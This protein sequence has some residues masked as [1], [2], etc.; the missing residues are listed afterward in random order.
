M[1]AK[2]SRHIATALALI[3]G[4][5]GV[6]GVLYAWG[7][8]PFRASTQ[9]TDDAYVRGQVTTLA[10]QV[11]GN[12]KLVAV[13]DYQRVAAGDLLIQL[14]DSSYVQQLASARAQLASAEASL[15][16]TAQDRSIAKSSVESADAA[17]DSAEAALAGAKAD[18]DRSSQLRERGVVTRSDDEDLQLSYRQATASLRQAKAQAETAR[19]KLAAI[20]IEER[21]REAGVQHARAAV[22]LAQIALD[23]TRI[24]APVDGRLGELS[25]H[26]GQ[27]VSAGTRLVTVVPDTIWVVANFKETQ[28]AGLQE[29][30]AVSFTVDALGKARLTGHIESFSPATGSQFSVL[31]S[32]NATGNFI[33]IAQRIPVRISVDA[34]QSAAAKLAPGMSVV[35]RADAQA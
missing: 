20:D 10:P 15:S 29:G 27:Y 35:V 25:A 18:M 34:N 26:L 2:A 19:Q 31:G 11:S 22:S 3:V 24:V 16:G 28:L 23:N 12:I 7:L 8:P 33:K 17:V 13:Q 6:V 21:S 32:S 14:D 4:V 1:L 9:T 30:Q 5:L